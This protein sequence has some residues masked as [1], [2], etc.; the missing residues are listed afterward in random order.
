MQQQNLMRLQMANQLLQ[1]GRLDQAETLYK[2]ILAVEPENLNCLQDLAKLYSRK[3]EPQLAIGALEKATRN[4]PENTEV[5]VQLGKLFQ[6]LGRFSEARAQFRAAL[7]LSPERSTLYYMI[8]T[9]TKFETYSSDLQWLEETYQQS[10]PYSQKRRKLAFSLGKAF[11]DLQQY[12]KAFDFFLEGNQIIRKTSQYSGEGMEQ[13][14]RVLRETFDAEYFQR[15]GNIGI[16]DDRPIFV[17]GM[18]RSGTTLV[19]QILAS[20][21]DVYGA[22]ETPYLQ[23]AAL[24]FG[25]ILDRP[26]PAG[27]DTLKP[28]VLRKSAN[29]YIEQI[30]A[31]SVTAPRV[32]DKGLGNHVYIGLISAM[33]PRTS[34]VVCRRN[35]M[36][37][38]LSI[39]QKDFGNHQLFSN[40]LEDIAQVYLLFSDLMDHWDRVAPARAVQIQ[41]EDLIKDPEASI[42]Y[43]L[44]RVGL[45]FHPACLSF[46]K[47]NRTVKTLSRTQVRQPIYHT[48]VG[49]WKNYV[50]HL[51][52]LMAALKQGA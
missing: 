11:D 39:F 51:E 43:L 36:D 37:M 49:R 13:A 44:D 6:E 31:T 40:S 42:R 20:H 48:S 18:P 22:G 30:T 16:N 7:E 47:T 34:I 3:G 8:A 29:R 19:E 5:R 45:E 50:S 10:E 25:K 14:Y 38:C 27:F 2:Q 46:Y 35:P 21:P 32:T 23:N 33:L 41:Y 17:T 12:D 24:E 26:F 9:I 15:Y 28:D 1:A 4:G 52:P